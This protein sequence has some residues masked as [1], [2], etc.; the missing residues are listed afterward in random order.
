MTVSKKRYGVGIVPGSFDPITFGHLDIIKRASE[1]CDVVFVAVMINDQKQYMFDLDTRLS[2]AKAAC[3]GIDNVS[4]ISSEGMLFELARELSAEVIVK[5]VRNDV[6]REYEEKM[7]EYNSAMY[8]RAETL[9]LEA[10][11]TLTEVS[12]TAVREL[13]NSNGELEGYLPDA[14]ITKINEMRGKL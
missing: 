3:E 8:P 9:L 6:D 7:A 2:I 14:V 1:L 11:A 13:I 5:G 4:V 10:D 12:S